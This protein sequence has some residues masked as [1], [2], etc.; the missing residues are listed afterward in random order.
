MMDAGLYC[1]VNSDDS[2]MFLTSLTNEYLTLAK[3]GFRWDELG[4]LNVN[5]LEA[6][7]LDEAVKGKYRAEWK[8]FTTSNN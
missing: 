2:A 6:T 8:Q 7:F 5:T 4:Q 3:Q 1:T